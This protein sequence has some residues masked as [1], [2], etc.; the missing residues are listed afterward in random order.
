[1]LNKYYIIEK[2]TSGD[3]ATDGLVTRIVCIVEKLEIAQDFCRKHPDFIY[4]EEEY[5]G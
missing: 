5:E 3:S 1:M 2:I 4:S